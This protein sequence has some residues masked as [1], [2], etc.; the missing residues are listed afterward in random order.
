MAIPTVVPA[1]QFWFT[2]VLPDRGHL[3]SRTLDEGNPGGY[4]CDIDRI[5]SLCLEHAVQ[6][7]ERLVD[8]SL[9]RDLLKAQAA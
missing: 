9:V 2:E 8:R 1:S 5:A 6:T 4:T 7:T 3:L